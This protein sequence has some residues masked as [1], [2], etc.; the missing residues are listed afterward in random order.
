MGDACMHGTPDR[1]VDLIGR[2]GEGG[3][4]GVTVL[5]FSA[6]LVGDVQLIAT[7]VLPQLAGR[8]QLASV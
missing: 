8:S 1:W 2:F 6:D 3:A 4:Q 7:E 5:L